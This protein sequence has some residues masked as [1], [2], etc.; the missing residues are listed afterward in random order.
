MHAVDGVDQGGGAAEMREDFVDVQLAAVAKEAA[1][2]FGGGLAVLGAPAGEAQPV[3]DQAVGEAP[4]RHDLEVDGG[5]Q[6]VGGKSGDAAEHVTAGVAQ[7]AHRHPA[8]FDGFARVEAR[9]QLEWHVKD[10]GGDGE[11][12]TSPAASGGHR[13]GDLERFARQHDARFFGEFAQGGEQGVG[14]VGVTASAGKTQLA[15]PGIVG[16]FGAAEEQHRILGLAGAHD[17][18]CR[19]WLRFSHLR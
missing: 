6:E 16:A 17:R 1:D 19:F 2:F 18:D 7:H 15:R 8:R 5:E 11:V 12:G 3:G 4:Q 9:G 13:K 10:E 14:V